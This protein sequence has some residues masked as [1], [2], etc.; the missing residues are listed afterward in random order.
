MADGLIH[1]GSMVEHGRAFAPSEVCSD[2][3]YWQNFT[4]LS[5]PKFHE[6]ISTYLLRPARDDLDLSSD[7]DNQEQESF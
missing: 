4:K 1:L 3:A 2:D 6:A 7:P 5:P